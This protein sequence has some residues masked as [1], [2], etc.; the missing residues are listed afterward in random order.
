MEV[1]N[2][3]DTDA[4]YKVSSGTQGSGMN[5]HK[6][7]DVEDAVG[8]PTIP[9]G[10]RVEHKPKSPGPYTVYFVVKGEEVVK[11]VHSD[12]ERVALVKAGGG[13]RVDSN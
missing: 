3:T 13:F 9:P 4:K 2:T 8:W 12:T 10:G 7:F 1:T 6:P 11:N 5:P